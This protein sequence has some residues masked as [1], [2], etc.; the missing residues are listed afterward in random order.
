MGSGWERCQVA[1][2]LQRL[3]WCWTACG[4]GVVLGE[5]GLVAT[6]EAQDHE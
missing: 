3:G 1:F 4:S 6:R 2:M 5:E